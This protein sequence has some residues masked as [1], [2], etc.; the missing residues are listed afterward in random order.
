MVDLS[1][2]AVVILNYNTSD[3]LAR[4]LPTLINYSGEAQIFVADNAS[5]DDSV[6]YVKENHPTVT[7]IELQENYGFC[8]GYNEAFKQ[9]DAEYSVLLNSDV[10]V[11]ENW[12]TPLIA[13]LERD[14]SIAACQPKINA[15]H[16]PT[17]FEHAGAAGGFIDFLGYP[18]CRG[19]IFDTVEKDE[20]QYND[21]QRVFW[22]SGAC[23]CVR[24]HLF[25]QFGGFDEDFFAHMEEIDLCWRWQNAGYQVF[26]TPESKV[27]HI[28]GGTLS[29]DNPQKVYLNFRNGLFLLFKNLPTSKL[30]YKIWLRML[31][32]G[33][34][35]LKF[36]FSGFLSNFIAVLKA[37]LH[38]YI[39]IPSLI[40]KRNKTNLPLRKE[41]VIYLKSIV[42]SYYL[43][44]KK[45]FSALQ[46]T[47]L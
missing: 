39:A 20:G 28:G 40:K 13:L 7:C 30:F 6:A 35:G 21:K 38:F 22:A 12:L 34:A 9:I 10:E 42:L 45:K 14:P 19:R 11:T 24:T 47:K 33:L 18:F 25:K 2:V 44:N 31:L 8:K 5:T 3:L 4:F 17:H 36:L 43:K 29:Y 32:D 23:M 26:F 27:F 41:K 16:L 46:W 1:K 15:Y 37:H